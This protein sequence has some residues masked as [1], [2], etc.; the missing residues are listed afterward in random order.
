MKTAKFT[1]II[2]LLCVAAMLISML[3]ACGTASSEVGHG[4]DNQ[5]KPSAQNPDSTEEPINIIDSKE[6]KLEKSE[7]ESELDLQ[8]LPASMI[9][10][11]YYR[12][13]LIANT[14]DYDELTKNYLV[15]DSLNQLQEI[16]KNLPEK[17]E[18]YVGGDTDY[19]KETMSLD[20]LCDLYSQFPFSEESIVVVQLPQTSSTWS[21][22]I[23]SLELC[24]KELR[25]T[26]KWGPE[27]LEGYSEDMIDTAVFLPIPKEF[28]SVINKV[29]IEEII[30][31]G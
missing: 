10:I 6:T 21:A 22:Y 28:V 11:L 9:R 3:S 19:S 7:T 17:A 24:G 25:V 12:N 16:L 13:L 15:I 4:S 27:K 29:T 26:C 2:G 5:A 31:F 23:S 14:I 20:T 1:R 18:E 8:S 30:L